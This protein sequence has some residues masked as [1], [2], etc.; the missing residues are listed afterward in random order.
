MPLGPVA[1]QLLAEVECAD[2]RVLPG[3]GAALYRRQHTG[4]AAGLDQ[5]T[6]AE[7]RRLWQVYRGR[8]PARPAC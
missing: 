6:A 8:R 5:P 4:S 7:W 3:L 1:H 2:A